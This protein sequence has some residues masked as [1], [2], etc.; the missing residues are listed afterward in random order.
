MFESNDLY[1][2]VCK[3]CRTSCVDACM[4]GGVCIGCLV[5]WLIDW[6]A[7]FISAGT[8]QR[9]S[10]ESMFSVA[11]WLSEHLQAICGWVSSS[12][13]Q[14]DTAQCYSWWNLSE[15]VTVSFKPS[16]ATFKIS[17]CETDER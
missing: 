13:Y 3:S 4:C 12:H 6:C 16:Y 9:S 7:I 15:V 17:T 14:L 1:K 10:I 5:G 8:Y 2:F 11:R